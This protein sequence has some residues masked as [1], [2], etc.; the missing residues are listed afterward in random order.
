M[1]IIASLKRRAWI[2]AYELEEAR[3]VSAAKGRYLR[4]AGCCVSLSFLTLFRGTT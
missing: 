4:S 2:A 3:E 1:S